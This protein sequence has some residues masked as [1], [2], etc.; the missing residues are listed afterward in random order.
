MNKLFKKSGKVRLTGDMPLTLSARMFLGKDNPQ[1]A[2]FDKEEFLKY[3]ESLR[4]S[5]IED[6]KVFIESMRL[7]LKLEGKM[8][9]RVDRGGRT[10]VYPTFILPRGPLGVKLILES[11]I[12]AFM[13]DYLNGT[14]VIDFNLEE[15]IAEAERD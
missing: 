5:E 13:K 2:Y 11:N 4:D 14:I 10:Y 3:G 15:L 1:L 6:L 8:R 12:E 7:G 9:K